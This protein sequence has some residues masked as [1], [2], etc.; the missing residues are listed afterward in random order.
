[1]GAPRARGWLKSLGSE[2]F[3]MGIG[4]HRQVTPTLANGWA[5][6]TDR[7]VDS[8]WVCA[9]SRSVPVDYSVMT[10]ISTENAIEVERRFDPTIYPYALT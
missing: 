5:C 8:G 7:E 10:I 1:M 4:D 2:G 6:G 9:G 3:Q